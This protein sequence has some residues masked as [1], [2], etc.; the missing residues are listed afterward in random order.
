MLPQPQLRFLLADDRSQIFTAWG[1]VA[2]V[3]DLAGEVSVR[4][5][6]DSVG[7]FD[8]AML[9]SGVIVPLQEADL[10]D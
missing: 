3:V 5:S 1:A 7:S 8:R 10:I 4:V 6:A 2:N 9:Q